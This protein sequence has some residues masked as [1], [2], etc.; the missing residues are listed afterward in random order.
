MKKLI[1]LLSILFILA[2]LV[3]AQE[4]GAYRG[5]HGGGRGYHGGGYGYRGLGAGLVVGGLL[6]WGL[7]PAYRYYP[8]YPPAYYPPP[9]SYYYPPSGYYPPPAGY[10]YPPPRRPYYP[11][12]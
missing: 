10:Y 8:Y 9:P 6:G 2:L 7:A 12:Y 4:A 3:P 11:P 1:C 5:G